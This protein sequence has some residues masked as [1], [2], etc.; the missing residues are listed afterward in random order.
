MN[1]RGHK[2][3]KNKIPIIPI[4]LLI[5]CLAIVVLS[6]QRIEKARKIVEQERY[7]RM[8]AEE[9]VEAMRGK[10]NKVEASLNDAQEQTERIQVILEQ[11]K[12]ELIAL[13]AELDKNKKI[14]EDL[15]KKLES[16]A[17]QQVIPSPVPSME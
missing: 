1:K 4:V 2:T 15:Q 11:E 12:Q 6:T 13:R 17:I 7:Q 14:K 3:V 5:I 8:V 16:T 10:I 9:Q